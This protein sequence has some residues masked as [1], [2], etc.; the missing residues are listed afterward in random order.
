MEA[1]AI[2]ILMDVHKQKGIHSE[3]SQGADKICTV[4]FI[5]EPKYNDCILKGWSKL[6]WPI[7]VGL[8]HDLDE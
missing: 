7:Q 4:I 1:A 2:R 5:N 3:R 6:K 8:W